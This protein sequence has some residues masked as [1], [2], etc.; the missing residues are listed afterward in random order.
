MSSR[1]KYVDSTVLD[2][3][4]A[5][6]LASLL[7]KNNFIFLSIGLFHRAF[8]STRP[9]TCENE[10]GQVDFGN[11]SST[12]TCPHSWGPNFSCL[13]LLGII[14][15]QLYFIWNYWTF[16]TLQLIVVDA[17]RQ[18][19]LSMVDKYPKVLWMSRLVCG[20]VDF[21]IHSST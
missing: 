13:T 17:E 9:Q 14:I 1:Q 10:C 16:H 21:R 19:M 6:H 5:I 11:H 15:S 4:W 2:S 12:K 7:T 3:K 18:S 8:V 20:Q